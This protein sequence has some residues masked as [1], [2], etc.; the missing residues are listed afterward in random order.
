MDF[1]LKTKLCSR[2]QLIPDVRLSTT[3]IAITELNK[4]IILEGFSPKHN[5]DRQLIQ[6]ALEKGD[7][8][9]DAVTRSAVTPATLHLLEPIN[10]TFLSSKAASWPVN[11]V[12]S[13]FRV[14]CK[15]QEEVYYLP[16]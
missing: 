14:D 9:P 7:Q 8:I 11:I 10:A 6:L 13:R 3:S 16:I 4:L 1:L 15:M 12:N 5:C 2:L